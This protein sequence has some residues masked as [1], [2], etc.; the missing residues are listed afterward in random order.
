MAKA[1]DWKGFR[2]GGMQEYITRR[3]DHDL[4]NLDRAQIS[5]LLH[6]YTPLTSCTLSPE[7]LYRAHRSCQQLE[8]ILNAVL[9]YVT[10][11]TNRDLPDP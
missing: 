11:R 4:H 7:K 9:K 1:N 3:T 10:R 8:G 5:A 6:V 2:R